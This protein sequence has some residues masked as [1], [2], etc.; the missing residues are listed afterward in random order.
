MIRSVIYNNRILL[1][2]VWYQDKTI[3]ICTITWS[4]HNQLCTHI[5]HKLYLLKKPN[6]CIVNL[7]SVN[8]NDI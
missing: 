5:P 3:L 2:T 4:R 1:L 7:K 6:L 8:K